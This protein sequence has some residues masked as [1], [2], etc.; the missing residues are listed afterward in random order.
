MSF[1]KMV[2][3]NSYQHR[4]GP[5]AAYRVGNSWQENCL[6]VGQQLT[7]GCLLNGQQLAGGAA[8]LMGIS[9]LSVRPSP[10]CRSNQRPQP[11]RHCRPDGMWVISRPSRCQL[12]DEPAESCPTVTCV[13][14]P[15][16]WSSTAKLSSLPL[17]TDQA[18]VCMLKGRTA[19]RC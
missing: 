11:N 10:C 14:S 12:G 17:Q 19:G 16:S 5:T 8:Y 9:S 13:K 6:S 1:L 3:C 2:G 18:G 4:K 15:S 7:R